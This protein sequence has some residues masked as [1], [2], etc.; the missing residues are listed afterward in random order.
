MTRG[1]PLIFLPLLTL[2]RP[3][4]KQIGRGL[5][6]PHHR[7]DS[8]RRLHFQLTERKWLRGLHA[9]PPGDRRRCP[10][11]F[12]AGRGWG[13]PQPPSA[14][15]PRLLTR[16]LLGQAKLARKRAIHFNAGVLGGYTASSRS[17]GMGR[18]CGLKIRWPQGRAGSSPASGTTLRMDSAGRGGKD[19]AMRPRAP[20]KAAS[21]QW[22]AM[23]GK[24]RRDAP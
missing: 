1:N 4:G 11:R 17:G 23:S 19:A 8:G 13:G 22:A 12:C 16:S 10:C 20:A 9:P 3:A 5:Q 2:S 24:A 7:F 18:R 15:D 6:S 21:A 14:V